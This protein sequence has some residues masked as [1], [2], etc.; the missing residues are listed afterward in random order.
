MKHG[1]HYRW[2]LVVAALSLLSRGAEAQNPYDEPTTDDEATAETPAEEA[3]TEEA[4]GEETLVEEA[5]AEE[6]A[7]DEPP[8]EASAADQLGS[9]AG[10]G[11][12]PAEE[13]VDAVVEA[14]EPAAAEEAVDDLLPD[15]EEELMGRRSV[16]GENISFR[17]GSG[18][19]IQSD[20]GDFQI[21]TRVRM[22][23]LYEL[24]AGD[25]GDALQQ[26]TIRRARLAFTGN[27]FGEDNYFKFEIAVS[28]RDESIRNNLED[29]DGPGQTPLL[30]FYVEFRQ[31][32]DVRLRVG[33]YKVPFNRQR[34][35]SS[36]NLQLVDRAIVNAEFNLDRDVGF[37]LRSKDFLGLG[38]LRYMAGAYMARGRGGVGLDDFH[39]MYIGR[40]ELHPFGFFHDK[41][42]VDFER[43][44]D[45][46]LALSFAYGYVDQG[47]GERGNRSSAPADGGTTDIHNVTADALFMLAG[48]SVY[49]E[50]ALRHG[51]RNAGGA[52]DDMGA[53]I[54]VEAPRNGYGVMVQTGYL[55]PR[56][57]FEISARYGARRAMGDITSLS[58]GNELGIGLSYYFAQHPFKIQLDVFNLWVD[59]FGEGDTRLRL[60]L[61]ASI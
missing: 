60:Q 61:Q 40:V 21:T 36:G 58:D 6:A 52:V 45:P 43:S 41:H 26:L 4:P 22:Q 48:W 17:P 59:E 15:G 19:R 18:V 44:R 46:R 9:P 55:L 1:P 38:V 8:A 50:F 23:T 35:T 25:G 27:F 30:D 49:G 24:I 3:P 56:A 33:Q 54:P 14:E 28:P 57:P 51:E 53:P 2:L 13:S 37:D 39:L 42:V 7:G 20:D 12:A 32:R 11:D 47:L 34:F 29:P 31:L 10:A 16:S 5:P